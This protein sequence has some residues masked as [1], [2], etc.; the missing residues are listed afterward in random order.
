MAEVLS[1]EL[2]NDLENVYKTVEDLLNLLD[3]RDFGKEN[4]DM[5]EFISQVRFRLEDM[6]GTLQKDIYE[7]DYLITKI[8]ALYPK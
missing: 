7:C 4:G 2:K 3:T 1:T 5:R 8:K 6:E